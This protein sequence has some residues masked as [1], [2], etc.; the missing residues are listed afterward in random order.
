MSGQF[1]K[2]T[3]RVGIGTVV[4]I[5]CILLVVSVGLV[6]SIKTPPSTGYGQLRNYPSQP[7]IA[8]T[9]DSDTLPEYGQGNGITVAGTWMDRW[10]L[11]Y[12]SGLGR[13]YLLVSAVSGKPVWDNPIRV[14]L[15][16]CALTDDG[17]VGCAVKLGE[18]ANGFYLADLD[19]GKLGSSTNLDSTATVIG[20]G[21]NFLRIDEAG[22]RAML[23][24]PSGDEIWTRTFASAVRARFE[25]NVLIMTGAD[26]ANA[27]IDT[28][29]G[30]NRIRCADCDINVYP[31]GITVQHN[32]YGQERV[33]FYAISGGRL[34]TSQ[35][36]YQSNKIEVV[37]GASTLPVLT[38]I[39]DATVQ[40]TQGRYEVRDPARSKA[41]WTITDPELSKVNTRPCGTVVALA[42][43]D[44][45]RSVYRLTD[46]KSVGRVPGPDADN[47]DADIDQLTCVG[48]SDRTMVF[49]NNNQLTGFA[50]ADGTKWE[51][52]IIGWAQGVDGYVVLH[53]GQSLSVLAPS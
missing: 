40:E 33:D 5:C 12:P 4:A 2:V 7:E 1:R 51:L 47:P 3:K 26:G 48:S 43:K 36:T 41:L 31:T 53:Q 42:R 20:V 21:S 11:S 46:G 9:V 32:A 15:G 8:W 13:A 25:N 6:L 44:R 45:S 52:P 38:G 17:V 18:A 27:V 19:S 14:G 30:A 35:P 50:I 23:A 28:A 39:G 49:A 10:L 24:T 37:R 16:S 29:T 22:Y 34:T